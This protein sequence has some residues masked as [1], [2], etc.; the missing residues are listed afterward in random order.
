MRDVTSKIIH[1]VFSCGPNDIPRLVIAIIVFS[2]ESIP[3]RGPFAHVVI[4]IHKIRFPCVAYCDSSSTVI[5]IKF[6]IF[7][8]ASLDHAYPNV[9]N[10]SFA[11]AMFNM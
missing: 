2:F 11:H 3:S 6:A 7:V 9:P 10:R 4:E 1:L 5:R 8:E